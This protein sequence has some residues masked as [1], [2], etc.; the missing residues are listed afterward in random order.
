VRQFGSDRTLTFSCQIGRASAP[1]FPQRLHIK[2]YVPYR[3]LR[4]SV[5]GRAVD[6]ALP[7]G[8]ALLPRNSVQL[9]IQRIE[10]ISL[11]GGSM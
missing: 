5:E 7:S 9:L 8:R 3:W 10:S 11:P 6:V 1:I 2:P 4:R